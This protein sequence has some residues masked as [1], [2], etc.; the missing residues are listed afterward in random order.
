[1]VFADTL[2]NTESQLYRTPVFVWTLDQAQDCEEERECNVS[3][4]HMLLSTN[5]SI[6]CIVI[7]NTF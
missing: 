3:G 4:A 2:I 5:S 1:M 6:Y 7:P